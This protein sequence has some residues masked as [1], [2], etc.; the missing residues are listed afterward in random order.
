LIKSIDSTDNYHGQE[1]LREKADRHPATVQGWRVHFR[2]LV[3]L[4]RRRGWVGIRKT[5]PLIVLEKEPLR[6]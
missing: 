5:Q 4:A 3:K 6:G 2:H 1:W